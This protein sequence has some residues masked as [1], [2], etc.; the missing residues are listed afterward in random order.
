MLLS[1][2]VK[3][4]KALNLKLYKE[5]IILYLKEKER[6]TI[7]ELFNSGILPVMNELN[8]LAVMYYEGTIS[9]Q[10]ENRPIDFYIEVKLCQDVK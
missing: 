6:A 10:L 1:S 9:M 2:K 5:D 8:F 4:F 7:K 3:R